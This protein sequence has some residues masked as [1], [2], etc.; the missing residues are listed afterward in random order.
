MYG[1]LLFSWYFGCERECTR[2]IQKANF[3]ELL[4][5][6]R[7]RGKHLLYIKIYIPKLLLNVVTPGIEA[8][9]ITGNKFLYSCVKELCCLWAQPRFDTCQLLVIVEALWSQPVLRVGKQVLIARSEIRVV[10]TVVKQLQVE[11]P[12]QCSSVSSCMRAHIVI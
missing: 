2:S 11:M 1:H 8:L 6:Q 4:T 10:R 9:I 3:G 12:Q 5:E 7:M